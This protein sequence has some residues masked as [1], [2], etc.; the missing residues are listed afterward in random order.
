MARNT[1]ST[2]N[3]FRRFLRHWKNVFLFSVG[4]FFIFIGSLILWASFM[5]LPDFGEFP[6]RKV[7]QSTKIYDR[8]GEVLLYDVHQEVKR[9]VVHFEGISLWAKN[10]SIAIEDREFYN[11]SGISVR[12]ISRAILY[13]G[14]RGGGSTITQQVVKKTLLTD[15]K[16]ITRKFKEIILAFRLEQAFSK[17]EIL[18]LYLNEIPYGGSMYGIG[19]AS[20]TFFGKKA[21][22]LTLAQS[23]YLA[24]IPNAPTYYSPYGNHRDKLE[25][26]KNLVLR[27]M[28]EVG[29]ITNEEY[30]TT[31]VE[32]VEFLPREPRGIRAPHFVEWVKEYLANKYGDLAVREN[33][34]RVITTLNY[35][36]Q[37]KAESVISSYGP[38]IEKNFEAKNMALVA[39]DPK[40]GQVLAMVGSRDYFDVKNEGNFNVALA[41]RQPGST[42]KPFVYAT[43]FMKGYT[44]ET[45]IFDL[46]TNFSTNCDAKGVP[47]SPLVKPE[48]CYMPENYD[49][50]YRG[51]VSMRDALAQS[52]N[53]PAVKT[54]YLAG[55]KDSLTMARRMGIESLGGANLYGLTLVL[56]GG[57]VSL[58]DLTG[59]YGVFANDGMR[60]QTTQ[61]LRIEDKD[62]V[63][64][65]EFKQKSEQ[66]V[67]SEIARSVTNILSNNAART[68]EFGANSALYF[69][70]KDVAVKTGTTN[71]YRDVWTVG[72]TPHISVGMWAGN[73]DNSPLHKNIAGFIIT[74]VWHA[75]ME[76]AM[77]ITPSERF[78]AQEKEDLTSL[79][80]PLQGIWQGGEK[81]IIDQASGKL[82][83]SLTP[84][85]ARIT[86]VVPNIHTILHWINK[87]SPRGIPP[88]N[89]QNDSQYLLWEIPV[90]EWVLRQGFVEGDRSFIPTE[91]DTSRTPDAIPVVSMSGVD[92]NKSYKIDENISFYVSVVSKYP[93]SSVEFYLNGELVDKKNISPFI[94]SFLPSSMS[95]I[96]MKNIIDIVVYDSVFNKGVF[97]TQLIIEE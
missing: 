83:T 21:I 97:S 23:A 76:E 12:G 74:P 66:V 14:T 40:N 48:D 73:N 18:A 16:L 36:L 37:Q 53:I 3:K 84:I 13:G 67:P 69:P 63:V 9:T 62:G 87:N 25:E 85:E 52:L 81:Y 96:Y 6:E 72:Y 71:D 46:K 34:Y 4:G 89:P 49:G 41:H 60:N 29:F 20:M 7:A 80:A 78:V 86:L 5:K 27:R 42:F 92:Y 2:K 58:L 68:P 10:A 32:K 43:A 90:R 11:H 91:Y 77:K 93:V 19:E 59:S 50:K 88:I 55:I 65:E 31:L 64:V 45:T 15:E 56:G 94:F 35:E 17:D 1:R 82:A 8:T 33:G 61:I 79:P 28:Y 44:P 75:F 30:K 47:F 39:V 26:R 57:E 95:S 54:L 70:G 22:D 38:D 24:A 51:P